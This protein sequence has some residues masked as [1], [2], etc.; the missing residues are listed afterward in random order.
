MAPSCRRLGIASAKLGRRA[1]RDVA[2]NA[3]E[4]WVAAEACRERGLQQRAL[5][6]GS[7]AGLV[8]FE[9]PL[10]ALAVSELDSRE[11]GLL[12]EETAEP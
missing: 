11:A 7:I 10:H 8:A 4:L 9:E 6:P 1:A 3:V 2:K 5:P 12:F